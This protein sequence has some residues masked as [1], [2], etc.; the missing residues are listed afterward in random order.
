M[1]SFV[2]YSRLD[3]FNILDPIIRIMIEQQHQVHEQKNNHVVYLA[4]QLR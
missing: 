1:N 2:F 4:F 3:T